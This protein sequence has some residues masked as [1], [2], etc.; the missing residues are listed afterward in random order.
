MIVAA[1]HVRH[2][3]AKRRQAVGKP[4]FARYQNEEEN[5]TDNF[6]NRIS[7]KR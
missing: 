5:R 7:I 4:G 1:S 6:A 2:G 3:M